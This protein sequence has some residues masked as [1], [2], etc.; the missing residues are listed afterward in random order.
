MSIRGVTRST[1]EQDTTT[2]LYVID[3]T[4]VVRASTASSALAQLESAVAAHQSVAQI[5]R[6][7]AE[8]IAQAIDAEADDMR[9]E[10]SAPTQAA[11]IARRIG[12]TP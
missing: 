2:G 10:W 12:G 6:E 1:I 7:V 8:E 9:G 3:A 4:I 11:A 5:R